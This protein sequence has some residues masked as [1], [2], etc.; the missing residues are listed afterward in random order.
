[1]LS[2]LSLSFIYKNFED[3]TYLL[4]SLW[5][6]LSLKIHQNSRIPHYFLNFCQN[7]YVTLFLH[8]LTTW[9]AHHGVK[10]NY[11][12]F[13]SCNEVWYIAHLQDLFKFP[14]LTSICCALG[15]QKYQSYFNHQ[16]C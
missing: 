3:F 15:N 4:L 14:I 2:V 11:D 10:I 12:K 5:P 13:Q 9:L 1:M 16:A 7:G 6:K 8:L